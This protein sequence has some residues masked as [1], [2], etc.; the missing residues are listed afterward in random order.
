MPATGAGI[1][2]VEG[3]G[4]PGR[5]LL[6]ARRAVRLLYAVRLAAGPGFVVRAVLSKIE[7]DPQ[8]AGCS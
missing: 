8:L 6:G 7:R 5:E 1:V 4:E 3:G 2:S